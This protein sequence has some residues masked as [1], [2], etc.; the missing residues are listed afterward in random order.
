MCTYFKDT[1]G[2][3]TSHRLL[4]LNKEEKQTNETK[5]HDQAV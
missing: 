1:S 4:N 3:S 5:R 2:L